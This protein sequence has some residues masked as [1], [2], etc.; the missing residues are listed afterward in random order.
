VR[1][2]LRASPSALGDLSSPMAL[3]TGGQDGRVPGRRRREGWGYRRVEIIRPK[4]PGPVVACSPSACRRDRP[5]G[6]HHGSSPARILRRWG[7]TPPKGAHGRR[8]GD[9]RRGVRQSESRVRQPSWVGRRS[10]SARWS[11]ACLVLRPCHAPRG[12]L[13]TA[14]GRE[15]D[16][17]SVVAT[18]D[19]CPRLPAGE[20]GR[21]QR[22]GEVI[23][24]FTPVQATAREHPTPRLGGRQVHFVLSQERPQSPSHQ[25]AACPAEPAP[26]LARRPIARPGD[27]SR[28]APA[29]GPRPVAVLARSAGSR[30]APGRAPAPAIVPPVARS[31]DSSAADRAAP[32]SPI[33]PPAAF[34]GGSWWSR[35]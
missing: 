17:A 25:F 4:L 7:H 26:R 13:G 11:R 12:E 24:P 23:A 22:A 30:A 5:A 2:G 31:S 29:A 34:S 14:L 18:R 19:P 16:G 1:A 20:D 15:D 33:P 28:S 6:R 27:R 10:P 35:R 8:P 3:G 21:A 9:R 32:S